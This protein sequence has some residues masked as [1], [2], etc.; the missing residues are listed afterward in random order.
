MD[1]ELRLL[2]ES[3][4]F[5]VLRCLGS[6]RWTSSLP[7]GAPVFCLILRYLRSEIPYLT[8]VVRLSR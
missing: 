7:F 3:R 2:S 6:F 1:A 8:K 4:G 5:G